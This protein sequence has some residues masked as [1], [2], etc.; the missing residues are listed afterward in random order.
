MNGN[1]MIVFQIKP[2]KNNKTRGEIDY[3]F[4]LTQK[5]TIDTKIK[6]MFQ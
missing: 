4:S 1:F 6:L 2:L 5:I 3:W